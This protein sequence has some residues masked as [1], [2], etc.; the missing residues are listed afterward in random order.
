MAIGLTAALLLVFGLPALRVTP[1]VESAGTG[2]YLYVTSYITRE[3][4]RYDARTGAFVDIFV[5][6]RS[7]GLDSPEGMAFGPDGNLYVAS[8]GSDQVLRYDG[9]TGAFIDIFV[10]GP[11]AYPVPGNYGMALPQDLVFGPDGN[12]YVGFGF[13]TCLGQFGHFHCGS[14]SVQR[15]N[16]T[17]GAFIDI[18]VPM[19]SGGL[20]GLHRLTYGPDGNLYI[21]TSPGPL[22]TEYAVLRYNGQTGAFMGALVSEPGRPEALYDLT[23]GPDNHLYTTN[24]TCNSVDRYDGAT[25]ARIDTFVKGGCAAVPYPPPGNGGLNGATDL[26]FGPDGNLYVISA[27]SDAILRYNGATGDFVDAFVSPGRGGLRGPTGMV[28]HT[29]SVKKQGLP[30]LVTVTQRTSPSQSVQR[31]GTLTYA[32]IATNRDKGSAT[33]VAI[34]L[35]FDPQLIQVLDAQFSRPGAWVSELKNDAVIIQTG[36]LGGGDVV[37]A[38]VRMVVQ[39]AAANGARL[40]QRLTYR[41]EDASGGGQG[42]GNLPVVVVGDEDTN[43]SLYSLSVAPSSMA[44]GSTLAFQGDI[45]EP[46]EPVALWYNTPDGRVVTAGRIIANDDGMIRRELDTA[47]LAS[48]YYSMVAYG[49]RSEF[50]AVV[51]FEIR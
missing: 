51:A 1:A 23:F 45:F 5:R 25:G 7:G 4:L 31:G 30:A 24:T 29:G 2:M 41:W 49:I 43:Q 8:A 11:T 22:Y 3:V 46:G 13:A 21:A 18:F 32:I 19:G 37:T 34:T 36:S 16:G 35:P 42:R 9:R 33:D 6:S 44:S 10:N 48:G 28:F 14:S 15:Y 17:T 27:H 47:G 20:S 12:L 39:P 50:T 38:T 40:S 26:L